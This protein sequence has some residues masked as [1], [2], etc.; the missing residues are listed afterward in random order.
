MSEQRE[1][2]SSPPKMDPVKLKEMNEHRETWCAV[3]RMP[4]QDWCRKNMRHYEK[5]LKSTVFQDIG[6]VQESRTNFKVEE[7]VH[8]E[9][10]HFPR[11]HCESI[12]YL[13]PEVEY[14]Y[15]LMFALQS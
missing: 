1:T 8:R 4:E 3:E 9:R 7:P 12:G 10:R 14:S 2:E 13:R 11:K 5:H 15:S 6:P